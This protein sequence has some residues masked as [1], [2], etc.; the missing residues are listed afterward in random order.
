MGS[1]DLFSLKGKVIVVTG[2]TGIL[3]GSF[4]NAIA[5]M[6]GI[7]II[8]GRNGDI[9]KQRAGE[10]IA[11]GGEAMS[12]VADVLEEKDLLIARDLILEKYGTIDGLVN[13]AGGNIPEG[14]L[15]PDADVFSMNIE[16]MKKA[17]VLNV[18]GTIFISMFLDRY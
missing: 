18:W 7:P 10:I 9:A 3:G 11:N 2:G 1:H 17:M 5:E 14:V 13:G 16:G 8:I 15:Q 4:V 12:I 6:G